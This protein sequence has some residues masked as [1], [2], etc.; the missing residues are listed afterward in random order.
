[1]GSHPK[2]ECSEA[3][4]CFPY[5]I[6]YI[7]IAYFKATGLSHEGSMNMIELCVNTE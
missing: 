7:L 2:A 1:M 4:P 3:L 5:M 6:A